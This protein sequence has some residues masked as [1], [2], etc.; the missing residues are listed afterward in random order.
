MST[1]LATWKKNDTRA[2]VLIFGFSVIVFAAV[3][4]LG[5]VTLFANP[6]FNVHVFALANAIIN[7]IVTL[8]LIAGL[9][10]VK[11]KRYRLH[12][13]IMITAMVLSII[14]LLSYICHHLFATEARFGDSDHNGI[15]SDQEK[16]AAGNERWVYYALLG[17]HI[18]LA[19]IALPLIL[20]TA[21][22][23]LIGEFERH[24]KLVRITW[25]LWLYVAITGVIVYVMISPYYN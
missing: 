16:L 2:R 22:R 18:P 4:V 3:S 20:F 23:A 1:L 8:L 11:L 5:R 15:L 24:R 13:G 10:A 17:T 14:F 19:G 6:G 12:K 21:Y 25:P 7:S 9:T